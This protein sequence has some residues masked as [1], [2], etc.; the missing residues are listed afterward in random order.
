MF[1]HYLNKKDLCTFF[2]K[3]CQESPYFGA[4]WLAHT[5][6]EAE[7]LRLDQLPI[8][9]HQANSDNFYASRG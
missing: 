8:Y 9:R 3:D 7:K 1:N 5:L 2:F 4:L 6:S